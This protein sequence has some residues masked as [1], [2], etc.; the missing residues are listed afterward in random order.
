M[1]LDEQ[2]VASL[3]LRE[4]WPIHRIANIN[5]MRI[6]HLQDFF[7]RMVEVL[8]GKKHPK[9]YHLNGSECHGELSPKLIRYNKPKPYNSQLKILTNS[10]VAPSHHPPPSFVEIVLITTFIDLFPSIIILF[11][12]SI[13]AVKKIEETPPWL[14]EP[15]QH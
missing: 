7:N 15:G 8:T 1:D 12:S 6:S 2:L 9:V 10:I 13:D 14:I 5:Q 11:I 4:E 3:H